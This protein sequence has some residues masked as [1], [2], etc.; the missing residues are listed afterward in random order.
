MGAKVLAAAHVACLKVAADLVGAGNVVAAGAGDG[1]PGVGGVAASGVQLLAAVVADKG[2]HA[3]AVGIVRDQRADVRA[4]AELGLKVVRRGV[5][6]A[7]GHL[8]AAAAPGLVA[9]EDP[10]RRCQAAARERVG[11]R[12]PVADALVHLLASVIVVGHV[13]TLG[14]VCGGTEAGD[15]L[16]GGGGNDSCGELHFVRK[17]EQR[18]L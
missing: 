11:P 14:L 16:G 18:V 8:D 13:D 4:T 17:M 7:A 1:A 9:L 2:R 12:E 15:G 6:V 3:A 10:R 5:A